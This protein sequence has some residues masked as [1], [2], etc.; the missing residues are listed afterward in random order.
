MTT[1]PDG[2]RLRRLPLN[3]QAAPWWHLLDPAERRRAARLP[4]HAVRDRFVVRRGLVRRELALRV[5][6]EPHTLE[7]RATP[8]GRPYLP[9]HLRLRFSVSHGGPLAVLAATRD[10]TAVGVD[11]ERIDAAC[12]TGA[13]VTLAAARP[14]RALSAA[15]LTAVPHPATCPDAPLPRHATALVPLGECP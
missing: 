7:V 8:D 3:Q 11:V 1:P 9:A 6:V 15:R 12:F 13:E 10:G 5:G 4:S 2:V 14:C